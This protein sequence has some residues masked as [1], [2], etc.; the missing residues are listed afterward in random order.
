[1]DFPALS[2]PLPSSLHLLIVGAPLQI[3]AAARHKEH[4]V[5]WTD[6]RGQ[7]IITPVEPAAGEAAQDGPIHFLFGF[8]AAALTVIAL[9]GPARECVLL[10]R[11]LAGLIQIGVFRY[12]SLHDPR[13]QH[14]LPLVMKARHKQ[15]KRARPEQGGRR[16]HQTSMGE[17]IKHAAIQ[18][19]DSREVIAQ[20]CSHA[21]S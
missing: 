11:P 4:L 12:L 14:H 18:G 20:G 10:P 17:V 1:M 3:G 21:P 5:E 2:L 15:A 6:R 9:M 16:K 19:I 8:G 7:R 13:V